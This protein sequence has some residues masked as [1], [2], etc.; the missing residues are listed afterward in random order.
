MLLVSLATAV[1]PVLLVILVSLATAEAV[2]V[3]SQASLAT[4]VDRVT[5]VLVSLALVALAVQTVS[6]EVDLR[7][8]V[9]LVATAAQ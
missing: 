3:D 5:A 6:V 1:H 9:A 4:A 7:A 8:L 2:L